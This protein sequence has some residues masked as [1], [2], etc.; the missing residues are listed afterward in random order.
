[1][2]DGSHDELTDWLGEVGDWWLGNQTM[3]SALQ[4]AGYSVEHVWGEGSH[5]TKHA[6]AVFP[7]AMRFL[8]A[9][10]PQPVTARVSQNNMLSAT[11]LPGEAWVGVTKPE[12]SVETFLSASEQHKALAP[13]TAG[14]EYLTEPTTGKLWLQRSTG[15]K[16]VVDTGLQHPTGVAVS[17]DGLWLAV[18]ES[19]T[20]WGYSYQIQPDGA[21]Q[22]KQRFYWFH[23]PDYADDSGAE[24]L[25]VD[26][27]GRLYAATRLGVQVFDHNGRSRA[28]LPLPGGEARAIAFDPRHLDVLYVRCADG[29]IY[30]RKFKVPGVLPGGAALQVPN[31]G[32]G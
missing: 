4:F 24:G 32:P 12:K 23:V 11:L 16:T 31:W 10:W 26:R 18:A 28:I 2:Q 30:R 5:D 17:P 19:R 3:L 15:K 27:D 20:H 8:W 6:T 7:D 29:H 21:L 1:M 14:D 9:D 22:N 13:G 25:A